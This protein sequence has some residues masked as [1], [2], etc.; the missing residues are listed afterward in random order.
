[1]SHRAMAA[2]IRNSGA[3]IMPRRDSARIPM[4]VIAMKRIPASSVTSFSFQ[5][6]DWCTVN[7]V[8]PVWKANQPTTIVARNPEAMV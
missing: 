8:R 7:P 4:K 6:N 1:M 5:P 2:T 3:A